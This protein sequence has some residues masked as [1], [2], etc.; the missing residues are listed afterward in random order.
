M[1]ITKKQCD[2]GQQGDDNILTLGDRASIR[3]KF[4]YKPE[5]IRTGYN[6]LLAECKIKLIGKITKV[7]E[8]QINVV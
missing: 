3:F 8:E 1:Q 7:F 2:R 4:C 5:F 6:I